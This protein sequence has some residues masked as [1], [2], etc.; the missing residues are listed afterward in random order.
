MCD[1]LSSQEEPIRSRRSST[2]H[3]RRKEK[4]LGIKGI[5]GHGSQKEKTD[6]SSSAIWQAMSEKGDGSLGNSLIPSL[7]LTFSPLFPLPFFFFF[8][9][10]LRLHCSSRQWAPWLS[11]RSVH[12]DIA[13]FSWC[14]ILLHDFSHFII[15]FFF[16]SFSIFQ[17]SL[18]HNRRAAA[19]VPV[20]ASCRW[21]MHWWRWGGAPPFVEVFL[22]SF[23]LEAKTPRI[24]QSCCLYVKRGCIC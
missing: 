10:S 16:S 5:E 11:V 8:F 9:L 19:V 13:I 4:S 23:R 20:M 1:L 17:W 6:Q 2:L 3:K 22:L 14:F 12:A 15:L 7:S 18:A 21:A 24:F